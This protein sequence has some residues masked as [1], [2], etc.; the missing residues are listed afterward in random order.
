VAF[1]GYF[2]IFEIW[3]IVMMVLIFS[4]AFGTTKGKA[5]AVVLPLIVLSLLFRV[6]A[7]VFQ[8]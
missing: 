2:S 5:F 3:W 4:T 6:G 1:L 8:R 7:A